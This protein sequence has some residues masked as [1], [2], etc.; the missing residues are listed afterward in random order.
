MGSII[1][2]LDFTVDTQSHQLQKA[3]IRV[4]IT[5][6]AYKLLLYF[7]HNPNVTIDRKSLTEHV[8]SNRIVSETSL[9]KLIQRLRNILGDTVQHKNIVG[10]VHGEGFIFLP[11][12]LVTEK[13]TGIKDDHQ[14]TTNKPKYKLLIYSLLPIILLIYYAKTGLENNDDIPL[15]SQAKANPMVLTLIPNVTNLTD[16]KQKW[17]TQGGMHYLHEKFKSIQSLKIKQISLNKIAKNNP[18]RFS[19]DLTNNNKS[20]SLLIVSVKEQNQ[21]FE[22]EVKIRNDKGILADKLFKSSTIKSIYDEIYL[23]AIDEL[24]VKES[25]TNNA[26]ASTLSENRYAVEN[27]IR[28][29]A[30]QISG[31][32]QQAIKYFELAIDEDKDFWL[33]WY[34]LSISYRKQG[35]Y[36]KAMSIVN[37]FE[38]IPLSNS[39][40]VKVLNSKANIHNA[41]GSFQLAI[42]EIDSALSIAQDNE[43]AIILIAKSYSARRL[44]QFNIAKDSANESIRLTELYDSKNYDGLGRSYS[45]LSAIHKDMNNIVLA[46]QAAN[47]AIKLIT[48]S[49]NNRYAAKLKL[50]LSSIVA[51]NGQWI[52]AENLVAD[53]L[54]TLENLNANLEA[55]TAYMRLIDFQLIAGKFDLARQNFDALTNLMP[56]ISSQDQKSFYLITKVDLLLNT[57]QLIQTEKSLIELKKSIISDYQLMNY[58]LLAMRYYNKIDNKQGWHKVALEFTEIKKFAENPLAFITQAQLADRDNKNEFALDAFEQAK[59]YAIK[60][61]SIRVAN[62]IFVPYLEYLIK[63]GDEFRAQENLLALEKFNIPVYPYLKLKAQIYSKQ[64]KEFEAVALLQELKIKSGGHWNIDDQLLLEKYNSH[65]KKTNN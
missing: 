37:A 24:K 52:K 20:D 65:I 6:T 9:D 17:M 57:N 3:G 54:I 23:W 49:G 48:K 47:K 41:K 46:E 30:A 64:G 14:K 51:K 55:S 58:Y 45:T 62:A 42:D 40:R 36:E 4:D 35:N 26:F 13:I 50:R 60:M 44:G 2:F 53:A 1:K 29:I 39:F 63:H 28:G 31:D 5:S 22:A 59:S 21:Q 11:E 61:D 38:N 8:W 43:K 19:I 10:T 34:Q 32:A 33:A 7:L 56:T 12:V 25:K 27:Y 15:I 18:E 16:T